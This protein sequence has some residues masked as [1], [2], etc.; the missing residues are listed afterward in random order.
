M[1]SRI[2]MTILIYISVLLLIFYYKPAMMFDA[3]GNIKHFDYDTT[4]TSVSL[5]SIETMLPII[6]II[7]YF[8]VIICEL[9]F[10]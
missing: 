8:V 3:E 7:C 1:F 6:A 2:T 9:I 10:L 5:L 4:I